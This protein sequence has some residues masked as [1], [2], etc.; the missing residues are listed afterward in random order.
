MPTE[1]DDN[2]KSLRFAGTR[3][4][5]HVFL[6]DFRDLQTTEFRPESR[7]N[8]NLSLKGIGLLQ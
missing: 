7:K 3:P 5:T 2:S 8:F 4:A 6:D 1:T